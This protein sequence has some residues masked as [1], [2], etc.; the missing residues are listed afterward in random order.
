MNVFAF[1]TVTA[2]VIATASFRHLRPDFCR[3]TSERILS[4]SFDFVIVRAVAFMAL[5]MSSVTPVLLGLG[6][7]QKSEV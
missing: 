4:E 1:Q 2:V 6:S 5:L 7:F 3:R